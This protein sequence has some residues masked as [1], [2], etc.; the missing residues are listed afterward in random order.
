M[1]VAVQARYERMAAELQKLR[2]ANG[3]AGLPDFE[4]EEALRDALVATEEQKRQVPPLACTRLPLYICQSHPT[5]CLACNVPAA[6]SP[7]E[8]SIGSC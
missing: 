1:V 7:L 2:E 6:G 8:P 5:S 4:A 3:Q